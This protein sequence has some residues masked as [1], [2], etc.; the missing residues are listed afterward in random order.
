MIAVPLLL[1]VGGHECFTMLLNYLL[2]CC[3]TINHLLHCNSDGWVRVRQSSFR[4]HQL[5][6]CHGLAHLQNTSLGI[7]SILFPGSWADVPPNAHGAVADTI[8]PSL[9]IDQSSTCQAKAYMRQY[10]RAQNLREDICSPLHQQYDSVTLVKRDGNSIRSPLAAF[11]IRSDSS[12]LR[13]FSST[14]LQSESC[15]QPGQQVRQQV[16]RH[17]RCL[18]EFMQIIPGFLPKV[19][20]FPFS[21]CIQRK[22]ITVHSV[23]GR[24]KQVVAASAQQTA[25]T[26]E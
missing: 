26:G 17:G 7:R 22:V 24:M 14:Y 11:R 2:N 4:Q 18:P 15:H 10:V 12:I 19:L 5:D 6:S 20:C 8:L 1:T 9:H 25:S 21:P 16:L 13:S 23:S 3:S